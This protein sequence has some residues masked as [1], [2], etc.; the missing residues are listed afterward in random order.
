M[1]KV[2][3]LE[4]DGFGNRLLMDLKPVLY[5]KASTLFVD[6]VDFVGEGARGW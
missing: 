5:R 6:T 4:S 1:D 3:F 2:A